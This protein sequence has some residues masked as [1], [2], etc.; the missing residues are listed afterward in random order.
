[1]KPNFQERCS[2]QDYRMLF[3]TSAEE[4]RW[5]C[6]TLTGDDSLSERA[7]DAAL[8]QSLHGSS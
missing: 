1:M 6:Y 8:E 4:L 2:E 5:L 3:A 7:M